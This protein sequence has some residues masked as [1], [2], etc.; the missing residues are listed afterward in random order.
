M[1]ITVQLKL[2]ERQNEFL[3]LLF[4]THFLRVDEKKQNYKRPNSAKRK[5]P[6]KRR[7]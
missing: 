7:R 3:V 1:Y 6:V 5:K 2:E 4:G